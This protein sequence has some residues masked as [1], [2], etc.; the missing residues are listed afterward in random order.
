MK[1]DYSIDRSSYSFRF[2][3]QETLLKTFEANIKIEVIQKLFFEVAEHF[4][5]VTFSYTESK[6]YTS[7]VFCR[8][9]MNLTEDYQKFRENIW[10]ILESVFKVTDSNYEKIKI[11]TSLE[12]EG[13]NEIFEVD[14]KYIINILEEISVKNPFESAVL[15]DKFKRQRGL[16]ENRLET[17]LDNEKWKLYDMLLTRQESWCHLVGV[18]VWLAI[19]GKEFVEFVKQILNSSSHII[20][21]FILLPS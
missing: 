20:F 21:E 16:Y 11:L 6:G 7:A 4:L 13:K 1:R 12:Y 10:K 19:L 2:R 14:K 18:R 9:S 15:Y 5:K 17:L 8:V 3:T